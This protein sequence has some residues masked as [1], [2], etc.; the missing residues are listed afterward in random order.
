MTGVYIF[1]NTVAG[2]NNCLRKIKNE[3][4]KGKQIK[5]SARE[6]EKIA[7]ITGKKMH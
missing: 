2:E 7:S 5:K 4:A 6:K 3:Y 1:Q